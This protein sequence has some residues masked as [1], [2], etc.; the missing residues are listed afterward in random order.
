MIL[1]NSTFRV[2]LLPERVENFLLISET[3]KEIPRPPVRVA[4][5]FPPGLKDG[6]PYRPT[7]GR[8]EPLEPLGFFLSVSTAAIPSE[9]EEGA[10]PLPAEFRFARRFPLGGGP[11]QR[12]S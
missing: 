5:R 3:F 12:R 7:V 11:W 10:G 2:K 8:L 1:S 6:I 9:W 4:L